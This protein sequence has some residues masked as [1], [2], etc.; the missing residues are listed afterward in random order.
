VRDLDFRQ[1]Y[2]F[3]S[4]SGG[5]GGGSLHLNIKK[6]SQEKVLKG[7]L[8]KLTMMESV[9]SAL[10]LEGIIKQVRLTQALIMVVLVEEA[11]C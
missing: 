7:R 5:G 1:C 2:V 3:D 8:P 9:N 10:D 6:N 4:K 11:V